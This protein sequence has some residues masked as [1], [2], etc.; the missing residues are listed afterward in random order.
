MENK[1]DMIQ[2]LADRKELQKIQ[3]RMNT[4]FSVS[5]IEVKICPDCGA[6]HISDMEQC[7]M[8]IMAAEI[9]T[10]NM[11]FID[12]DFKTGMGNCKYHCSPTCHPGQI[13]HDK[14]HYGCTHKAWPQNKYGDFVPFVDCDG[15]ISKCELKGKKFAHSYKR[16]KSLSLRYAKEK[17][18]RLEK[19]IAEYNERC[20]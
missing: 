11:M 4:N 15:D 7:D 10:K 19:E 20:S 12:G 17:V 13:D 2:V 16:G 5:V 9:E 1:I 14:W 8:C 3:Q 6:E 18:A